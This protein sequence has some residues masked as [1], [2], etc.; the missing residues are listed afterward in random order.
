MKLARII[1]LF[2]LSVVLFFSLYASLKDIGKSQEGS[3]RI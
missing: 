2:S 1:A 3:L